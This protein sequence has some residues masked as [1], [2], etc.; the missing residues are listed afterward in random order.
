MSHRTV[1]ESFLRC[2]EPPRSSRA[3]NVVY[4]H[5]LPG[6]KSSTDADA[7]AAPSA[8]PDVVLGLHRR[9]RRGVVLVEH[10]REGHVVGDLRAH[11]V[12]V[13]VDPPAVAADGEGAG[14]DALP[15]GNALGAGVAV[16]R[17]EVVPAR[18]VGDDGGRGPPRLATGRHCPRIWLLLLWVGRGFFAALR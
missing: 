17:Q 10:Q 2:S 4:T 9:R 13:V 15:D 18:R 1:K 3:T 6:V 16:D 14:L 7:S 8:S 5:P 12:G 11:A